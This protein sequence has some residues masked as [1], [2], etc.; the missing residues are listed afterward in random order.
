MT[1]KEIDNLLRNFGEALT[2]D[3]E[4]IGVAIALSNKDAKNVAM[5][6]YGNP[7]ELGYMLSKAVESIM[8]AF[9]AQEDIDEF[10]RGLVETMQF[11]N[12]KKRK[13]SK[14]LH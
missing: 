14:Y 7:Y 6:C 1:G 4:S 5:A 11:L 9:D 10:S 3:G 12:N 8:G 2:K 13:K